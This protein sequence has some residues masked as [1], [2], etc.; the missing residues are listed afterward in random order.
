VITLILVTGHT[1]NCLNLKR[2]TAGN[3]ITEILRAE[4][5]VEFQPGPSAVHVVELPLPRELP[6]LPAF[7]VVESPRKLPVVDDVELSWGLPAVNPS[8]NITAALC[9]KAMYGN[10]VAASPRPC[11][12]NQRSRWRS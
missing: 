9:C 8:S 6:E 1:L 2:A 12:W 4:Y 11:L 10:V 3:A 5:L 7:Y